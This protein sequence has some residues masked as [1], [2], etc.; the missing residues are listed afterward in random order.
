MSIE[1]EYYGLPMEDTIK[2]I[3][4]ATSH[5]RWKHKVFAKNK[6]HAFSVLLEEVHELYNAM[7]N[8]GEERTKEEAL[9]CIAVLVRIVEG[10]TK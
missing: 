3:K 1:I 2:G 4:K 5:A 6:Y 7:L 10:D 8:E 9:D